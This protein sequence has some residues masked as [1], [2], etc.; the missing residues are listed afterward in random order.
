MKS[1]FSAGLILLTA[2]V[3]GAEVPATFKVGEFA[4]KRPEKW[5]W[6]ETAPNGM[7]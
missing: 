6:V 4:F 1:M 3:F 7:R 2:S 5:T